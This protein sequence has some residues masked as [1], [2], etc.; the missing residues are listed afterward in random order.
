MFFPDSSVLLP[1][2]ICGVD[3][4]IICHAL[5]IHG[6]RCSFPK[7][8]PSISGQ[9]S[10]IFLKN[11]R[12]LIVVHR[13]NRVLGEDKFISSHQRESTWVILY[14]QFWMRDDRV[15]NSMQKTW[16]YLPCTSSHQCYDFSSCREFCEQ[17]E[18]IRIFS[19]NSS[20]IVK[21]RVDGRLRCLD[22]F[23]LRR[24]PFR[25]IPLNP[26]ATD[27]LWFFVHFFQCELVEFRICFSIGICSTLSIL[28]IQSWWY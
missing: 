7:A 18:N 1:L 20:K 2:Y 22:E 6:L 9:K 21:T 10:R 13:R 23:P 19:K 16:R 3:I 17:N 28:C 24:A 25:F 15:E 14:F 26:H 5:C 12:Y 4:Y 11:I 27:D 8:N